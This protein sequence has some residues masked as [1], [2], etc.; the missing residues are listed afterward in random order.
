MQFDVT[1]ADRTDDATDPVA[2][3][4]CCA[5]GCTPTPDMYCPHPG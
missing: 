2:P 4:T 5:G 1:D 3:G